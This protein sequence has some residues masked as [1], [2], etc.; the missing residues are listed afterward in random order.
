MEAKKEKR[1]TKISTKAIRPIM[2][3]YQFRKHKKFNPTLNGERAKP[4]PKYTLKLH[5]R[6][7]RLI[8]SG[9]FFYGVL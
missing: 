5:I 7:I 4:H 1:F 2:N 8:L 3:Y 6:F 9:G